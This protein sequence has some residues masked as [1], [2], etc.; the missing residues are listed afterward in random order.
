M[1]ESTTDGSDGK[2]ARLIRDYDLE[3][4]GDELADR[5]TREGSDRMS[6]RDL[7]TYFNRALLR[8]A[9]RDADLSPLEY[10]VDAT[11]ETLTGSD[12]S[13]GV[14]TDTRLALQRDGVDVE[15]LETDFVSYQAIRS[16]LED[17]RGLEYDRPSDEEKRSTDLETIQRLQSR[18]RTV[19]EERIE[20]LAQTGRLDVQDVEVLLDVGILCKGCGTQYS[21]SELF[22]QGGC[23]CATNG[24]PSEGDD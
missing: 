17:R 9:L 18:T 12:A 15:R 7:A 22:E 8:A 24:E 5:W 6:L 1:T 11:Y 19:T 3:N 23:G 14:R 16:Y 20:H 4:M 10:D 21:V 13:A 2:V